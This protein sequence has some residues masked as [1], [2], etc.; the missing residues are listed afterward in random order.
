[1]RKYKKKFLEI[2]IIVNFKGKYFNVEKKVPQGSDGL[3]QL[4]SRIS[5]DTKDTCSL[6]SL[7]LLRKDK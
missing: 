5:I 4:F 6:R 3:F 2:L 7:I 1:M